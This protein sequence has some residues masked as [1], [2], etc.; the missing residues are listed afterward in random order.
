MSLDRELFRK[1]ILRLKDVFGEKYY[2]NERE[3]I[4]FNSMHGI[5][6][7]ELTQAVDYMIA[8]SKSHP[9][10]NDFNKAITIIRERNVMHDKI[11]DR[12]I[13]NNP[14][15]NT[16][17]IK[18]EIR[19]K[20]CEDSGLIYAT[21]KENGNEY[22]FKCFCSEGTNRYHGYN[23]PVWQRKFLPYFTYKGDLIEN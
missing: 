22:C 14:G 5:Q 21:S 3:T 4:L 16:K 9:L 2:S 19:C 12:S 18:S 13:I 10:L 11:A 17:P 7:H 20:F 6:G 15:Q 1:N 23:Y 8:N